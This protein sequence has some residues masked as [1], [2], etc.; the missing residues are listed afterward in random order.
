MIWKVQWTQS[1]G[2]SWFWHAV[3]GRLAGSWDMGPVHAKV[4]WKGFLYFEF[5]FL[6]F[7][8][9]LKW[10]VLKLELKKVGGDRTGR[11]ITATWVGGP[12]LASWL[13]RI[14]TAPSKTNFVPAITSTPR[15][16]TLQSTYFR[17]YYTRIYHMHT[18]I[19]T[20]GY[21]IIYTEY[22]I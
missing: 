5:F 7:I 22:Y 19:W 12:G 21:T 18:Y 6:F 17:Y 14:T 3:D 4:P 20:Y 8:N 9:S 15:P 10:V 2:A 16:I 13:R 11:W 1:L